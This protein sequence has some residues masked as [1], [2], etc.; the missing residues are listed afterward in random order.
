[1]T[2]DFRFLRYIK[3]ETPDSSVSE[4]TDRE[5]SSA[6]VSDFITLERGIAQKNSSQH[7]IASSS[8]SSGSNVKVN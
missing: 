8:S 7:E 3:Y 6:C 2:E 1:M 5:L 4:V